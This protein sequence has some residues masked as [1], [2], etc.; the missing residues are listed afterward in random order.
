MGSVLV[1]AYCARHN[2]PCNLYG[3]GTV[4]K[5]AGAQCMMEKTFS[6]LLLALGHPH[7]ITGS[8]QVDMVPELAQ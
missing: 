6:G 5:M 3:F 1:A 2:L 7:M 8:A 4:A